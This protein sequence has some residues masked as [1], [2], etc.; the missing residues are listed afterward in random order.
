MVG[1]LEVARV[2]VMVLAIGGCRAKPVAGEPCLTDE[3]SGLY[4]GWD[5]RR[6]R[7]SPDDVGCKAECKAGDPDSCISLA[8]TTQASSPRPEVADAL[9]ERACRLGRALA[10]TNYA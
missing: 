3:L 9:F 8:F 7:C 6:E 5:D 2:A 4:T 1:V 10:C